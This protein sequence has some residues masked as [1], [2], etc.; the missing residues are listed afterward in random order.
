MDV[1]FMGGGGSLSDETEDGD[2]LGG[3]WASLT[4]D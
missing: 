3:C 1:I 4:L 2:D